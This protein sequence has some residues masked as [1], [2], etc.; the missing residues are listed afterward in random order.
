MIAQL[1]PASMTH[2]SAAFTLEVD[3]TNFN[4]NAVVNFNNAAQTGTTWVNSAKLTVMI[5]ASAI[6]TA[7][8]VPVTVTNPGTPG[9]PYGGGTQS[10]TSA[11]VNF[12]IN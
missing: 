7:G 1:N 2:G 12:T 4:A 10:E 8:T 3:G 6:T 11:V 9:G 5:P